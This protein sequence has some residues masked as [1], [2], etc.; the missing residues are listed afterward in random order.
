[1]QTCE[2]RQTSAHRVT[3]NALCLQ[4]LSDWAGRKRLQI[5]KAHIAT[6]QSDLIREV[7][8]NTNNFTLVM[9]VSR[10]SSLGTSPS[11]SRHRRS[12]SGSGHSSTSPL[13]SPRVTRKNS[14]DRFIPNRNDID[15]DVTNFLLKEN[16]VP[17]A[18]DTS[19]T[20]ESYKTTIAETLFMNSPQKTSRVYNF[21]DE[22]LIVANENSPLRGGG[23]LRSGSSSDLLATASSP[24]RPNR[25]ISAN[26]EKVLDAPDMVDDYYLNLLDWSHENV[27]AI[28]L[29]NAVYLWN[30]TTGASS[31]LFHTE[32]EA[33]PVTS[34]AFS[35]EG[36]YIAVGLHNSSTEIW[37]VQS[38]QRLRTM[39]GHTQ[40]ISSLDW[41]NFVLSSGSRDSTIVNHDVRITNHAVSVLSGHTQEVCGLKWSTDGTQLASGSNDNLLHIW[42]PGTTTSPVFSFDHHHAAVKALAWCP[43]QRN[44]L[45]SG[46]GTQDRTLRF[47]NTQTGTCINS[48]DTKSQVCSIS[49][50]HTM[51]E[52]VTSHGY[53]QNQ[54][55]VWKY[56][57]MT[58]MAELKGHTSRVLH[59]AQ[60]PDH[61]TIATAAADETLRFWKIFDTKESTPRKRG[62]EVFSPSFNKSIPSTRI[63]TA[64]HPMEKPKGFLT[65]RLRSKSISDPNLLKAR[66]TSNR[67]RK[68]ADIK[69]STHK[70]GTKFLSTCLSGDAESLKN[71]LSKCADKNEEGVLLKSKDEKSGD[72]GIHLSC[73]SKSLECVQFILTRRPDVNS[74]NEAGETGLH[75]A[76]KNG[77]LDLILYLLKAGA[78]VDAE[79]S[80]KRT[81]LWYVIDKS[82]DELFKRIAT[83]IGSQGEQEMMTFHRGYQYG[84]ETLL[85][86]GTRYVNL[87]DK[88]GDTPLHLAARNG[89]TSIVSALVFKGAD[90]YIKDKQGRIAD[91]IALSSGHRDTLYWLY[92]YKQDNK[93]DMIQPKPR[94][95]VQEAKDLEEKKASIEK[96]MKELSINHKEAKAAGKLAEQK[97]I[98]DEINDLEEQ[99]LTAEEKQLDI[100]EQLLKERA[101]ANKERLTER[102]AKSSSMTILPTKLGQRAMSVYPQPKK[103]DETLPPGWEERTDIRGRTYWLNRA[104]K[105]TVWEHPTLVSP[106]RPRSSSISDPR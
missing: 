47:W 11:S 31:E 105:K 71:L 52:L 70:N 92:K 86:I 68:S 101:T 51:K 54:L 55:I 37:D 2:S 65:L 93:L 67:P 42:S 29:G 24:V 39:N 1:M 44:L 78:R 97:S 27:V 38:C 10:R 6:F 36:S 26:P 103:R 16:T 87:T 3:P 33:N 20:L 21:S 74:I 76:I 81:P 62:T 18:N 73:Y 85:N 5:L 90:L 32:E 60:G 41:N 102:K 14:A 96:T 35:K 56:P 45:A 50:S 104:E 94:N 99:L 9:S 23:F 98:L 61:K 22:S 17:N 59:M 4:R 34:L 46:G 43:W 58:K 82:D 7:T 28:G 53:S 89:F 75:I 106:E 66:T 30:A 64:A 15:I 83:T 40:R 79:D 77:Q 25:H 95:L 8:S 69:C 63:I 49:W 91:E 80:T 84:V 12:S 88:D 13:S 19:S 48:I 72:N 100:E 57:T